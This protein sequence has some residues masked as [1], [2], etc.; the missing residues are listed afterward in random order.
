MNNNISRYS[1]RFV[2]IGGIILFVIGVAGIIAPKISS[3]YEVKNLSYR[4]LSEENENFQPQPEIFA[5]ELPTIVEVQ[6]GDQKDRDPFVST[7]S[8]Y[9]HLKSNNKVEDPN[10][11]TKI[12]IPSINLEAPVISADFHNQQI[13]DDYFGKWEAP[14]RFAAGWHPGRRRRRPSWP[15]SG[16]PA[17][18]HRRS[19]KTTSPDESRA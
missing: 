15:T 4:L 11:P 13:G 7:F 18:S 1:N 14:D 8:S 6:N 12:V 17:R 9:I 3:T 19:R 16:R 2:I 10:I 5:V